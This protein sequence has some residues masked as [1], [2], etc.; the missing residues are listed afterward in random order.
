[1]KKHLILSLLTAII[2][3]AS[4]Q[5]ENDTTPTAIEGAYKIKSLSAK[6]NVIVTGSEGEK[7]VTTS[8]YTTINNQ[9]TLVFDQSNLTYTGLTYSIDTEAKYY[10]YL[11]NDLVDSASFPLQATLPSTNGVAPYKLIGADS[12]YFPQ[13]SVASGGMGNTQTLASGGRY[14]LNGNLLTITQHVSKDSTFQD[15]GE[16]FNLAESGVSTIVIEK[17]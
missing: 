7:I 15:S 4:C 14:T 6:T 16:T 1:M 5:K 17:Q 8:D 13:G 2:I 11:D 9:G 12:I 10:I 3:L